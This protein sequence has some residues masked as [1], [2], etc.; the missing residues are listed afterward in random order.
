MKEDLLN[1]KKRI[2]VWGAGYIGGTTAMAFASEGVKVM[3]YDISKEA[4]AGI[5]RGQLA[6]ANLE[7]WF[8]A[9]MK[10]F[11]DKGLVEAT[12][13]WELMKDEDIVVHFIAVPTEKDG[14]PWDDAIL[15]V[16]DKLKKIN[17]PLVIIESTLTPGRLDTF[18]IGDLRIGVAPRRDWFHSPEQNLKNLHR[19]YAGMDKEISEEMYDVLSIVC[20]H[21]LCASSYKVAELVKSVENSL[22]HVPAVYATQLAHAYPDLDIGEVLNLASTHW[23]I[24]RYYPSMGTGGYCIPLSSKYVLYGA[25][26]PDRLSILKATLDSDKE[27]PYFVANIVAKRVNGDVGVM[28]ICYKGDLKVHMLSPALPIIRRL[29]ETDGINVYVN[30]PYYTEEELKG[31]VGVEC[32]DYMKD[33]G[34]FDAL[35]VVTDH[36]VYKRMPRELLLS[37][38]KEGV[39]IYDNYGIW[40]RHASSFNERGIRYYKIGDPGWTQGE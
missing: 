29:K 5:M 4:V 39:L 21:L 14:E 6:V 24:P 36:K 30:D 3:C 18:D 20:D 15:D 17:P 16:I 19:V 7:Y 8:G 13:D 33:L 31:L 11:V 9:T 25:D 26:D 32:F 37:Q 38:L 10:E 40:K 28:G 27:E 22:L 34:R 35:I 2:G 1:G 23:R 12:N